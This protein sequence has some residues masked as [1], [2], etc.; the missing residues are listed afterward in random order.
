LLGGLNM[1]DY[2]R[3]FTGEGIPWGHLLSAS[4]TFC[5]NRFSQSLNIHERK[6]KALLHLDSS[7]IVLKKLLPLD[8]HQHD[9]LSCLPFLTIFKS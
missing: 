3:E 6:R 4:T 5:R 7:S 9:S 1:T 8:H 2:V